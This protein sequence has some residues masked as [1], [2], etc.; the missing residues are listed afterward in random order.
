MQAR[1]NSQRLPGKVLET[2]RE[3]P[4][5]ALQISRVSMSTELADICIATSDGVMDDPIA[6]LAHDLGVTC[7]R[8]SE[9]DV[10]ARFAKAAHHTSAEIVVRLT[11]DCPFHDAGVID[12]AVSMFRRS[13]IDYL[14]NALKRTYPIG[15]DCE[16]MSA[17]ALFNADEFAKS[18]VEREHVTPYLYRGSQSDEVVSLEIPVDLSSLRWTLDTAEDLHALR[19]IAERLPDESWMSSSWTDILAVVLNDPSLARMNDHVE[20]RHLRG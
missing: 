9:H 10:L 18:D 3:V 11:A 1:M 6:A 20:H 5:L 13:G 16:V 2:I 14:T 7:V 15:L 12:R 8:G 4:A 17:R 19:C